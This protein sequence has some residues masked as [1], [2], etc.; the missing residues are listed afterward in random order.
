MNILEAQKCYDF[1]L[2]QLISDNA[3]TIKKAEIRLKVYTVSPLHMKDFCSKS[4]FQ[5]QFVH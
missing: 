3:E 1:H 5:V 4:A 2:Q